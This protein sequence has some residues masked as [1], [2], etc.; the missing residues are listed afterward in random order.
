MK[1]ILQFDQ[2]TDKLE[3]RLFGHKRAEDYQSVVRKLLV[4]ALRPE[5]RWGGRSRGSFHSVNVNEKSGGSGKQVSV[6]DSDKVKN[7]LILSLATIL[8]VQG[9]F[10]SDSNSLPENHRRI[11][12]KFLEF[13]GQTASFKDK[14]LYIHKTPIL[15]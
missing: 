13:I 15:L 3:A 7:G 12:P 6:S 10:V 14:R 9:S 8:Q 11:L 4:R 1:E 5:F 2:D